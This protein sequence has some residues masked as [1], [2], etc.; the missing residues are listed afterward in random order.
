MSC[1]GDCCVAFPIGR[2]RADLWIDQNIEDGLD[3]LAMLVPLTI[4]EARER[5]ERFG[6]PAPT[7]E[8]REYFRCVHWDDGTRL[9]TNYD[10][11]PSMCRWYPYGRECEFGCGC[12]CD[13]APRVWEGDYA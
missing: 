6:L 8:T 1:T 13:R 7:D 3:I 5:R 9:C 4:Q 2:S 12:D 11:R 10:A